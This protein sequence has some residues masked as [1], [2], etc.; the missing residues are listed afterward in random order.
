[1]KTAGVPESTL[2]DTIGD[3]HEFTDNGVDVAYLPSVWGVTV[4]IS[5]S[6]ETM[7]RAEAKLKELYE[8]LDRKAGNLI[9]GEGKSITLSQV[10]G[11]LLTEKGLTLSTAESCTG[12][13]LANEITDIPGSS[14]YM[15]GGVVAYANEIKAELLDVSVTDL[16][17]YG[18]V[19]KE[20]A[21][22][23]ADGVRKRLKTD[24]GISTTGIAGPDGGSAEK[25]VGTV[26]MGFW[27]KGDHFALQA[28]L[29]NDRLLN[30]ERTVCI[31]LETVRRHLL[32]LDGYPYNL[33]AEKV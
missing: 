23:M 28:R 27:I 24:I 26:W 31:A 5:A 32:Q 1:L 2:S 17:R 11:E 22:Q 3:L 33:K 14:R 6:G 29:T 7:L 30:K 18:A 25:P 4:R 8:M 15:A 21:L 20:V 10:L 19:S 9:Y 13:L 12:G 16:K